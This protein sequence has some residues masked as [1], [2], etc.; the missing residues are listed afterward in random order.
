VIPGVD[1]INSLFFKTGY[2][3][4]DV[5]LLVYLEDAYTN[6]MRKDFNFEDTGQRQEY[7]YNTKDIKITN[8]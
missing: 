5:Y 1:N 6:S 2:K 8:F 4:H 3:S 7:I